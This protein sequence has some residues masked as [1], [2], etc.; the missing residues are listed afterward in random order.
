MSLD[1]E[2]LDENY[3]GRRDNDTNEFNRPG[4]SR[5]R[6][7]HVIPQFLLSNVATG[8]PDKNILDCGLDLLLKW[9]RS[10]WRKVERDV[11]DDVQMRK[12]LAAVFRDDQLLC[13]IDITES[14]NG[15]ED[16]IHE[17]TYMLALD[18]H[19][20]EMCNHAEAV[21]SAREQ[22]DPEC[23]DYLMP[24]ESFFEIVGLFIL[25]A[26]KSKG[27]WQEPLRMLIKKQYERRDFS[28]MVLETV[29]LEYRHTA[30][31]TD[32]DVITKRRR[33]ESAMARLYQEALDVETLDEMGGRWM[34]RLFW[35]R[36]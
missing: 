14:R 12:M 32:H 5:P 34:G 2:F 3:W 9:R 8:F 20:Q 11:S 23:G 25:P 7:S 10:G 18:A 31:S 22:F 26:A 6:P 15:S 29:P 27:V 33:R 4:L 17:S 36:E 13:V 30:G 28:T 16:Y 24:K 1:T 19:S 21:I 35:L